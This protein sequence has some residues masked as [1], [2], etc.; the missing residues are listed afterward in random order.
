MEMIYSM[1]RIWS[2]SASTRMT[3]RILHCLEI[4][5]T[6]QKMRGTTIISRFLAKRTRTMVSSKMW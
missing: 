2:P 6:M 5:K 4:A 1:M 3:F